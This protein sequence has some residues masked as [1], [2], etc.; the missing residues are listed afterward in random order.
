LVASS[1]ARSLSNFEMSAPETKALPPAPVSTTTRTSS[2][3]AKPSRIFA[4]AAHMS[5]DTAL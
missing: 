5:S 1:V 3:L 4:V 2:S